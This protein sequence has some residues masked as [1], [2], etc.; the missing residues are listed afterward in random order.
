M[1]RASESEVVLVAAPHP[2]HKADPHPLFAEVAEQTN[3]P[4]VRKAVTNIL[5]Q[6]SL[7]ADIIHPNPAGYAQLAEAVAQ[8]L[9]T[10]GALPRARH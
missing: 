4:L 3:T 6:P 1:V 2:R 5:S 8:A 9:R 7:R 10:H